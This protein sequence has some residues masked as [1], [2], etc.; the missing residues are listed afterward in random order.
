[1][2]ND[3]AEA[4]CGFYTGTYGNLNSGNIAAKADGDQA[5]ADLFKT[6]QID[7]TRFRRSV[8][9]FDRSDEATGFYEPD[10][11]LRQV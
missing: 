3:F 6:Q 11:S 2:A 7:K 1:M 9:R 5:S 10:C 8:G 4:R